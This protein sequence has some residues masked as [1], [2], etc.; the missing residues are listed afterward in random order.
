MVPAVGAPIRSHFVVTG[1]GK[2]GTHFMQAVLVELGLPTTHEGVLEYHP[3]TRPE[4]NGMRGDCSWPA[5]MHLGALA[6]GTPVLHL[7]RDP[8][9]VVN[10]R[11]GENKLADDHPEF[12]IRNFV[13]RHMP[14]VFSDAHDDLGRT[15]LWVERWNR[16]LDRAPC[17][18][19]SLAYRRERVEDISA[20]PTV[21]ADVV[22]FLSGDSPGVDRSRAALRAVGTAVGHRAQHASLTWSDVRAHPDGAGVVQLAVDYGYL[23]A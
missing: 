3:V 15:L 17:R 2:C 1:S 8:L 7:V 23:P 19:P 20:D 21:L 10:A 12:V 11:F 22:H 14:D 6:P 9:A 18:H 16:S 13:R 4:W 5:A